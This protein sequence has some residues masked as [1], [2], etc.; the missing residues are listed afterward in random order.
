MDYLIS[1]VI[2]GKGVATQTGTAATNQRLATMPN[3]SSDWLTALPAGTQV[4]TRA[5]FS[6]LQLLRQSVASR[7]SPVSVAYSDDEVVAASSLSKL[8]SVG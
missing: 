4:D 3:T 1:S 2:I 6:E 8:L 5:G 7:R